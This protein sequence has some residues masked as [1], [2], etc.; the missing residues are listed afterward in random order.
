MSVFSHGQ[1]GTI[2][3]RL[4]AVRRPSAMSVSI[5]IITVSSLCWVS[6]GRDA[7][8]FTGN[9]RGEYRTQPAPGNANRREPA[10]P[11]ELALEQE[12]GH[13]TGRFRQRNGAW[14]QVQHSNRF[15][16][17]ACFDVRD[18]DGVDMRWCI[19][20]RGRRLTGLWSAGPEG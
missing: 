3:L 9:W 17:R 1:G 6:Y 12:S 14:Q 16:N 2:V 20:V 8:R 7:N 10:V 4:T 11:F 18:A 5:L 13:I 15:G 19:R